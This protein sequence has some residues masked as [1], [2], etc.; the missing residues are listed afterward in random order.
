MFA[1]ALWLA[2]GLAAAETIRVRGPAEVD[3]PKTQG[4]LTVSLVLYDSALGGNA[5]WRSPS[6]SADAAGWRWTFAGLEGPAD[7]DLLQRLTDEV[8]AQFESENTV[9]KPRHAFH[10]ASDSRTRDAVYEPGPAPER[11]IA[12]RTIDEALRRAPPDPESKPRAVVSETDDE[13]ID[14]GQGA[15]APPVAARPEPRA[16]ALSREPSIADLR[17][18]NELYFQALRA[19]RTGDA[20]LAIT[21]L[22]VALQINPANAEAKMAFE[23][24]RSESDVAPAPAGPAPRPESVQIAQDFYFAALRHYGNGRLPQAERALVKAAQADPTDQSI[25]TALVRLRR[26]ML[27]M[28]HVVH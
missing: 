8:Y 27:L 1:A 2:C 14:V 21:K 20:R 19:Y 24:I 22:D 25:A 12:I 3:A 5:L 18:S 26:E 16:A 15:I 4:P 17:L 11:V 28:P 6:F 7:K 13:G 23:R 10:R 9:F